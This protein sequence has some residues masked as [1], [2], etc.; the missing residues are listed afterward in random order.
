VILL[1]T[2]I[3]AFIG[4]A[5]PA[6]LWRFQPALADFPPVLVPLL[7]T[8]VVVAVM[9]WLVRRWAQAGDWSDRHRLALASGALL[10]HSVVGGLIFTKSATQGV[11]VLVLTLV[12]IGLL[13]LFAIKVRGRADALAASTQ[14]EE[15]LPL[16]AILHEPEQVAGQ[17]RRQ[18]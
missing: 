16:P 7:G 17:G 3:G 13:G 11:T 9:I 12:M 18:I 8:I 10:A 2:G 15:Q 4:L 14:S 6:L 1:V 5:L